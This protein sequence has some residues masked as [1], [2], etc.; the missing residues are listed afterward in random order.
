MKIRVMAN[1]QTLSVFFVQI[2]NSCHNLSLIRVAVGLI[3]FC[4]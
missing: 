1:T 2:L 3:G 4:V